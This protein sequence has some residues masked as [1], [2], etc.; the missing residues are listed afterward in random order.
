MDGR[1][2]REEDNELLSKSSPPQN[3]LKRGNLVV[4]L[5]QQLTV[6]GMEGVALPQKVESGGLPPHMD[7]LRHTSINN[8][9]TTNMIYVYSHEDRV[10]FLGDYLKYSS[11]YILPLCRRLTLLVSKSLV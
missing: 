11:L 9:R 4:G 2:Q 5:L 6:D 8:R 10:D 1:S 3:P 7:C